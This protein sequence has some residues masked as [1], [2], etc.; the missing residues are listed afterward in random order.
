MGAARRWRPQAARLALGAGPD[1]EHR[2]AAPDTSPEPVL[3]RDDVLR[4]ALS[5]LLQSQT[6]YAP[7]V[8]AAGVTTGILS[9]EVIS[10]F[11]SSDEAKVEEHA[12]AERP[13]S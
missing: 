2:P 5:D 4:D 13:L 3:D 7:V 8:D 10:D 1:R 12:A 6:H 11:L 9:M